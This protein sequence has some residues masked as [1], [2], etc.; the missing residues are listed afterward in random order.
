MVH[1]APRNVAVIEQMNKNI[2]HY[3]LIRKLGAG[4]SGV[5]Y[6]ALDTKL[7]RPV[8]LKMLHPGTT[9]SG[10]QA[11]AKILYEARIASA[12]EHP[13]VCT[14]YEVGAHDGVPFIVMQYVPGR[15]LDEWI[16]ESP[17]TLHLALSLAIQIADGLAE[18]HRLGILH[19]DLKPSNIIVSRS[20]TAK[21]LDFGLAKKMRDSLAHKEEPSQYSAS[22]SSDILGTTAYIAPEQFLHRSSSEQSDLFALGVILYEML[23]G[24]H[25]F[26]LFGATPE[27]TA[28]AIQYRAPHP[29]RSSN[30]PLEVQSTVLKALE[31]Q[32]SNRFASAAEFRDALKTHMKSL[33]LETGTIPGEASATIP[34]LKETPP[35]IG[36]FAS[37]AERF[38]PSREA[39]EQSIVVLPFE[40]INQE[41]DRRFYGL[42]LADAI[43]TRLA[44]IPSLIVRPTRTLISLKK[45]PSDPIQAGKLLTARHVLTG[46]YLQS[47]DGFTITWQLIDAQNSQI[48]AGESLTIPSL[49]LV[50]IQ[51]EIGDNV[52]ASLHGTED[53]PRPS[54]PTR[55][56]TLDPVA[57]D[58]YLEARGML[59]NFLLR[60]SRR[61]DLDEV[62][63]KFGFVLTKNPTFSHAHSGLGVAHL[64]YVRYGFGGSEY[65]QRAETSLERALDLDP[66]LREANV[67]R[68][69]IL[70][71]TGNKDS[72]K[73]TIQ[74]LYQ[75]ARK[76]PDVRRACGIML[77]LDGQQKQALQELSAALQLKSSKC[78]A[79][80]LPSRT[81]VFVL[82]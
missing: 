36:F 40:N 56:Q 51:N 63:T 32:P 69:Y 64:L 18:A 17:M 8:V 66:E 55:A 33:D 82:K 50:A 78:T 20:G 34:P 29:F 22:N 14:I 2:N 5:V 16:H 79:Y 12:I 30:I 77:R 35:K 10:D 24:V 38:T 13:N 71:A 15:T 72:A 74:R 81:C 45:L 62:I 52:F 54:I 60:S 46:S 73:K 48:L 31:K 4:A 80:L 70:L 11:M 59:A 26:G 7:R 65:L 68:I 41:H 25:P 42:A 9:S 76:D 21:I 44:R 47:S 37:L 23:T 67:F 75:R 43:A 27:G 3:E 28:R 53:L 19:R 58:A 57:S 1:T 6:Y 49:D 61:E 39:P